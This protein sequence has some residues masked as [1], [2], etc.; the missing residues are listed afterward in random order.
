MSNVIGMGF[1]VVVMLFVL[2]VEGGADAGQRAGMEGHKHGAAGES[3]SAHGQPAGPAKAWHALVVARDAVADSVDRGALGEV[4]ER[5]EPIPGLVS[6]LLEQSRDLS[7]HKR[8]RVEGAVRQVARVADA[9]HDAAD[10]GDAGGTRKAL[11]RLDGLL[12]LIRTQ[13]PEGM[14]ERGSDQGSGAAA[15][16]SSPGSA[17]SH[18]ER[19]RGLVDEEAQARVHVRALDS[20]RFVPPR[21]R[22]QAGVPTRIELENAGAAEHSLV[23]RT[24]GGDADWVHLHALPDS[25]VAATYRLEVPGRYS[26]VCAI[27]GHADAGMVGELV[28]ARQASSAE[29]R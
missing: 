18:A 4:H 24:P 20:L 19:P 10:R 23:V 6:E 17:H 27:P 29:R 9:L 11:G 8:A 2:P 13:F 12:L 22:V 5:A 1:L 16:P 25:T 21:I 3:G 28:V 26:F 14:L 7:P 15:H